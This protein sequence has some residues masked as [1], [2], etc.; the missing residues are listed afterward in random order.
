MFALTRP[1]ARADDVCTSHLGAVD[2]PVEMLLDDLVV[3]FLRAL[4]AVTNMQP[5]GD[6]LDAS[7]AANRRDSGSAATVGI[8]RT[9]LRRPACPR[10][11][12]RCSGARSRRRSRS[13]TARPSG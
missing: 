7:P 1:E 13:P 3:A 5:I 11:S 9:R 10:G 2:S 8:A 6:L 4:E 12:S